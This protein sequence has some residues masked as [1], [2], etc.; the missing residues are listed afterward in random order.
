MCS[1]HRDG[2]DS[3]YESMKI[4]K[5]SIINLTCSLTLNV[6]MTLKGQ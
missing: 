4:C 6:R 5:F 3:K 1:M 2:M